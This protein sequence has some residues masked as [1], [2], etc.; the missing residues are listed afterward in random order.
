MDSK[1]NL[2]LNYVKD[3]LKKISF[4]DDDI[5]MGYQAVKPNSRG[6]TDA[7][8][9]IKLQIQYITT[10]YSVY[11]SNSPKD[12]QAVMSFSI[13]GFMNTKEDAI[14]PALMEQMLTLSNTIIRESQSFEVYKLVDELNQSFIR[15]GL[16]VNN[17]AV[18][19]DK[20][21]LSEKS[22]PFVINYSISYVTLDNY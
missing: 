14:K 21:G 2:I 15:S 5:D 3:E 12:L 11:Q 17:M 9:K 20:F 16:I 22:I 10:D 18:I 7:V 19:N 4:V 6:R 1:Q 8:D 13:R